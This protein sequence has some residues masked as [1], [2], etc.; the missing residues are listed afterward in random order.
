[1][2]V[3]FP[4]FLLLLISSVGKHILYNFCP[5]NLIV[6]SNLHTLLKQSFNYFYALY[7]KFI[8]SVFFMAHCQCWKMSQVHLRRVYI[9]FCYVECSINGGFIVFSKYSISLLIFFWA[10]YPTHY[11]KWVLKSPTIRLA[12]KL[13][14]FFFFSKTWF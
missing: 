6:I 8:N 4:V 14:L 1:M 3:K 9:L 2:F 11:W 13:V 10:F 12:K 5:F 7:F